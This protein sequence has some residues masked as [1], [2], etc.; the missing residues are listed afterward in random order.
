MLPHGCSSKR[1][2]NAAVREGLAQGNAVIGQ[3]RFFRE[4]SYLPAF[5]ATGMHGIRKTVGCGAAAGDHDAAWCL[6][7]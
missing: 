5:E 4:N 2:V 6:C 7:A 1:E 3:V